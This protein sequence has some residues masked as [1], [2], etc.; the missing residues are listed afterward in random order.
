VLASQRVSELLLKITEDDR[1]RFLSL[2]LGKM[3]E[4][5]YL[6]YD[7]TSVS[8]YARGNE[9][10]KY[11]DT[12]NG[13][14]LPQI[15][16]AMLFGQKSRLPAYYRRMRGNNSDVSTLRATVKLLDVLGADA[17]HLVLDR[18]FYS[19]RNTETGPSGC[20]QRRRDPRSRSA[21]SATPGSS[22]S[23]APRSRTP[24][25]PWGSSTAPR[26]RSRTAST[27]RRTTST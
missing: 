18:G 20:L 23:S 3:S 15:N 14:S 2:W 16:L 25:T 1:Q 27:T 10:V 12:R 24:W 19:E 22:A 26:T 17:L 6:C 7:I 13:E 4:C 9:Y 8:S 21:G 11:G 5:D